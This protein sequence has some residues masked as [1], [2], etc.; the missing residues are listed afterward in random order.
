M[1]K[2]NRIKELEWRIAMLE[3]ADRWTAEDYAYMAKL[4][5]EYAELTNA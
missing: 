3:N 2:L 1:D 5:A 4:R